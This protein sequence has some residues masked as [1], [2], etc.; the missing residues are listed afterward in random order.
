VLAAAVAVRA[1]EGLLLPL[2]VSSWESGD[3]IQ[4]VGAVLI[5]AAVVVL[6][7][8]IVIAYAQRLLPSATQLLGWLGGR[9]TEHRYRE[10]LAALRAVPAWA[11][12]PAP[13][14][15][16]VARAMRAEDVRRGDEV[17]RQGEAGNCFYLIAEGA[18]EVFVDGEAQVRLGRGDYFGERAL[19]QRAPRAAT[20]VAVE[21]GRVFVLDQTSFDALLANDLAVR[22]RLEAAL[23]YREEVAQM[24]LFRD[25]SPG[26]LDLLLTR[27]V[28]LD[29]AA[30]QQIV[31]QGERGERFYV[32]RSGC[33]EVARDGTVLAQLGPGE[34]FGEIALLLDVPRTATVRAETNLILWE[35]TRED[36]EELQRRASEFRE[37][38][39]ETATMRLDQDSAVR[40]ARA[41]FG[42]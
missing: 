40:M 38:L 26:E 14:L 36:F 2:V 12:V 31:R 37:S 7:A 29:F 13:R 33:V 9:A 25:L 41:T 4:Q 15:L 28:P 1:W 30:G 20:V 6:V 21:P 17:V 16:E 11:E 18:F 39:L 5:A 10:A 42:I 32:I 23:A 24:P 27:L 34:A 8:A 35:L 22:A 3:V 19:L